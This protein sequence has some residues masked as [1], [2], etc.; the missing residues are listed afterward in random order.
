MYSTLVENLI[1]VTDDELTGRFRALEL[2]RRRSEAEMA[3][4]VQEGQRRALCAVDGH[5][6]MKHWVRAQIN[7][8]A[9]DATRL[10]RLATALN[11]VDGLGDALHN[12]HIG[13]AQAHELARLRAHP[14]VGDQLGSASSALLRHAEHLSYEEFRVVTRRWETLAD[15]DGAER[16][17]EA[18]AARRKASVIDVGGAIDVRASGGSGLVT[19]EL[20][21]IFERFV[22]AE[23]DKDVA[24]RT[25]E[26]GPDAPASMLPRTDAQRRFDAFVAI[27]RAAVVA[28][29]DGVAPVPVVYLLVGLNT[30]ERLVT[31]RVTGDDPGPGDDLDLD[32]DLGVERMEADTGT[33]VSP[34]DVLA[35]AVIGHVRR[36]VVDA[37]GVVVDAGRKRRLFS[38]VA[39]Q[40]A[41]LLAHSCDH[42][43]CTVPA[44]LCQVDHLAEWE[45][46]D[47]GTD[48]ANS[49]P[50]CNTHNPLKTAQRLRSKRDEFGNVVDFRSDGTAMAPV[51]RRLRFDD[52]DNDCHEVAENVVAEWERR[53]VRVEFCRLR[54]SDLEFIGSY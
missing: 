42:L 2:E 44:R 31:R 48:Q 6:T 46:D 3:A 54:T 49:K 29:A 16:D 19:A 8:S 13:I 25:A 21:G 14:R 11:T 45:R 35:A 37:K 51:G 22:Q 52:S 17:D 20:L 28:P 39:R 47:G 4:I 36:V 34:D 40:M 9:G 50:R 33:T 53:T 32:F 24:A 27:C 7:C 30:F 41:L 23:F 5:R 1:D 15:L 10:R 12:G 43:G 26:F 18:S 38:G